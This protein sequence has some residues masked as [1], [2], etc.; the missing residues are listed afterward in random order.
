MNAELLRELSRRPVD[1]R[2]KGFPDAPSVTLGELGEQSWNVLDG[3]LPL[4]VMVIKDAA[5]EHNLETM[6]RWCDD[7]GV[8]I[9]PHGKTAMAPQLV[10]RQFAHGAW[11]VTAATITQARI[12]HRFG[13]SRIIIANQVVD[14]AGL[15]WLRGALEVGLEIYTLVDSV[16]AVQ[17]ADEALRGVRSPLQ[18]LVELGAV[19]KRTGVRSV[20]EARAVAEAASVAPSLDVAGVEAYEAVLGASDDPAIIASI[21]GMMDE[22]SQVMKRLATDGVFSGREE[23]LITAGG[24]AYFDR[25]AAKLVGL[26]VGIPT[27]VIIRSGCYVV[28]DEGK[29]HRLSALDGRASGGPVLQPAMEL[30]SVVL[31]RP[32]PT[33]AVLGMGKRDASYDLSLPIPHTLQTKCGRRDVRDRLSVVNLYD[34]H[35]VVRVKP[36]T[37]IEVGDLVGA[38]I[39]HP[40]TAFDKWR[41]LPT[42]DDEYT[43]TGGVVTYF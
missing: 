33:L 9:A 30:W 41:L 8:S 35:A 34:Q 27:R 38:G 36:G 11:G 4:P 7:H 12:F 28:H 17:R 23:V 3:D 16:D 26:D 15:D 10:A 20:E 25:V 42:V 39:D 6:S 13:A 43:V 19:G 18:V 22:L 37:E 5:V 2:D 32:E 24:S 29:Y 14:H 31:S 21:D 40:C 1:W